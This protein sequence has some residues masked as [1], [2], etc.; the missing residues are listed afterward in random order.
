MISTLRRALP[1]AA[2][3]VLGFTLVHAQSLENSFAEASARASETKAAAQEAAKKEAP[4]V[5]G[6]RVRYKAP[7]LTLL[8]GNKCATDFRQINGREPL[9]MCD[10]DAG[11]PGVI[12]PMATLPFILHD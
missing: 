12:V 7:L 1:A 3:L 5:I 6:T 8:S 9:A 10:V 4:S 11:V 2:V